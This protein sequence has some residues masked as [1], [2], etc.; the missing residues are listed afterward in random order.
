V[1]AP[2][3]VIE[4]GEHVS[5]RAEPVYVGHADAR[6]AGLLTVQWPGGVE[7]PAQRGV[8]PRGGIETAALEDDRLVKVGL[9]QDRDVLRRVGRGVRVDQAEVNGRQVPGER[10]ADVG[11]RDLTPE[12]AAER[13]CDVHRRLVLRYPA[14]QPAGHVGV[15]AVAERIPSPF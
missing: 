9:P 10:H 1:P 4:L 6:A 14:L 13:R 12:R 15:I 7:Q 8:V 2:E 5:G 3:A 11:R